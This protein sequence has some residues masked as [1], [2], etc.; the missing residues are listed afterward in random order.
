M[1]ERQVRHR[2]VLRMQ[3]RL[4]RAQLQR[5][6]GS[7]RGR[8]C[9]LHG[10]HAGLRLDVRTDTGPNSDA[11]A[12]ELDLKLPRAHERRERSQVMTLI[13]ALH[14]LF[15]LDAELTFVGI[16]FWHSNPRLR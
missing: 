3:P 2:R 14:Y 6:D 15:N 10:G 1:R 7:S 4:G 12:V 13:R 16:F 8:I 9:E 11:D 5:D